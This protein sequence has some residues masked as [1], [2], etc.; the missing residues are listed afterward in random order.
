MERMESFEELGLGP[1]LVEALAAEGIE[2]PTPLQADVIP[3]VR[4][5]GPVVIG[6]GPGAGTLVA[7]GAPLLER[8]TAGEGEPRALILTPS[9]EAAEGLAG[10]LARLGATTGHTVAALGSPWALPQRADILFGTPADL[11]EAVGG[12]RVRL[13]GIEALVVDG[14]AAMEGTGSLELVRTLL[15]GVPATAQ[16]VVVTLPLTP[17]GAALVEGTVR[18]VVHVPPRPAE[19][20]AAPSE[21]PHRG[22][23]RY[24]VVGESR[25]DAVLPAVASL[26][27]GGEMHHVVVFCRSEDAAADLGDHLTL[28]GYLAGEVGDPD[29]PVW[30]AVD[31]MAARAV[32]READDPAVI[33]TLSADV[34]V[35]PDSLDRRHGS[36]GGGAVLARARELPHLREAAGQA[37]YRLR[38][39]PASVTSPLRDGVQA[40]RERLLTALEEEDL[41]LNLAVL[42]PLLAQRDALELAAAAVALLRRGGVSS[43]PGAPAAAEAAVQRPPAPP[44]WVR[45][46]LSVGEKDGVTTRDIVGAVTGEAGVQGTQ[47][48][49]VEIRDTFARVEVDGSVAGKVVKA[50]NGIT[51]RGRAVRADYDRGTGRAP[52]R[53]PGRGGAPGGGGSRGGRPG[54]SGPRSGGKPGDRPRG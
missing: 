14:L 6:A 44:S 3:V 49:K 23:L 36:G 22:E 25:P 11:R 39:W 29:A 7:Y 41:A 43:A 48:G 9:R 16:R 4:R 21:A 45:I 19:G 24:R 31:E 17:A 18:K 27:D 13:E 8:V 46:F 50:L 40:L 20:A 5:G 33:A 10:C 42:E 1:E 32:I 12:S 52:G 47:V 34:P 15:E 35:G 2:A 38:V 54:G 30:L 37:G 28:H 51:I 26:L 53:T